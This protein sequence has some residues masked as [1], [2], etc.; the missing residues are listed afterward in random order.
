MLELILDKKVQEEFD[1]DDAEFVRYIR[2]LNSADLLQIIDERMEIT[3]ANFHQVKQALYLG[4]MCVDQ[5]NSEKRSL[6]MILNTVARAYKTCLFKPI[7]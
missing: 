2:T 5:S 6:G 3:E 1:G 7:K 4:L